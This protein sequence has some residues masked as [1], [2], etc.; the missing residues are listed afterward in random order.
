M[1]QIWEEAKASISIDEVMTAA[2]IEA[3][4]TEG[5]IITAAE[6]LDEMKSSLLEIDTL[7]ITCAIRACW[8]AQ[9][10]SHHAAQFLYGLLL[11]R[12]LR[13]N[14]IT[15]TCLMG[16]YASAPLKDI[17]A[18]RSEMAAHGILPNK[19]FAETYLVSVLVLVKDEVINLRDVRQLAEYLRR[20]PAERLRAARAGIDGFKA[21]A[22]ELSGLSLR[23]DNAL[24]L[25]ED[26]A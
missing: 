21:E 12:G 2:R 6:V 1:R 13:P 8:E 4:A 17:L 26:D 15:L 7:H 18:V 10:Q 16:A 23:V 9:G 24:Q 5:D 22:V 19:V 20:R 14:I 11:N 3:A 25:L